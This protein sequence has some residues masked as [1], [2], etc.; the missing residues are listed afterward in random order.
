MSKAAEYCRTRQNSSTAVT[1]EQ[2]KSA[3]S[4]KQGS[5]LEWRQIKGLGIVTDSVN[6]VSLFGSQKGLTRIQTGS[7]P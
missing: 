1:V 6:S 3:G 2:K 7:D 5:E 4:G